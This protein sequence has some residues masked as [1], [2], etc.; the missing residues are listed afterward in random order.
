MSFFFPFFKELFPA[1]QIQF[2]QSN[3][4]NQRLIH[5]SIYFDHNNILLTVKVSVS[6]YAK[7][8]PFEA[9]S[10]IV[11]AISSSYIECYNCVTLA[12]DD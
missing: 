4:Y 7:S 6:M 8:M 11:S 2:K 3:L 1:K 5:H 10:S 12:P 9:F